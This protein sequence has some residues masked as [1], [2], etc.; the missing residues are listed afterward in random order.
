M[1]VRFLPSARELLTLKSRISVIVTYTIT[2]PLALSMC[3]HRCMRLDLETCIGSNVRRNIRETCDLTSQLC[4]P[5]AAA[6]LHLCW[7]TLQFPSFG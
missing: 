4:A 7:F 5:N 1:F 2:R 3:G 6:T